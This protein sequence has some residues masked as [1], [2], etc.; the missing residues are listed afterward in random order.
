[1]MERLWVISGRAWIREGGA[2]IGRA[3]FSAGSLIKL[4]SIDRYV[5]CS[6]VAR[7]LSIF[8]VFSSSGES[9]STTLVG[10]IEVMVVSFSVKFTVDVSAL[11]WM[12]IRGMSKVELSITSEKKSSIVP[13]F[14]SKSNLARYGG[15]R[16]KPISEAANNVGMTWKTYIT[17]SWYS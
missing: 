2:G 11:L 14:K 10:E 9:E 3:S 15:I 17:N 16:S 6:P 8:I 1:M 5:L 7:S 4:A 13:A 12:V